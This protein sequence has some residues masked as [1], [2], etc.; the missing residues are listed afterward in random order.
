MSRGPRGQKEEF[1]EVYDTVLYATGRYADTH[2]LQ[3]DKA[4]V[5]TDRKG[6]LVVDEREA[7]NVSHIFAIGDCAT[8]PCELT[9]VAIQ[10]GEML[11]RRLFGGSETLMD[12]NLIATTVFTPFELGMIGLTEEEVCTPAAKY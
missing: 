12:Y 6:Y 9:P 10:S 2:R 4:G 7:T 11:A 1:E 3:L 5:K 8:S